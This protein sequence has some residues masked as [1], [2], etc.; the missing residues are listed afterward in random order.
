ML[1][2]FRNCYPQGSLVGELIDIDRGLYIV[3][4]SVQVEGIILATGLAAADKVEIAE[5]KARERA[6]AALRLESEGVRGNSV[7][8]SQKD[9]TSTV[10]HQTQSV[11]TSKQSAA[12]NGSEINNY[13]NV[14]NLSVPQAATPLEIPQAM[15]SPAPPVVEAETTSESETAPL[16]PVDSQTVPDTVTDN[17]GNLFEGTF[18]NQEAEMATVPLEAE[19]L[20]AMPSADSTV[21]DTTVK[22]DFYAIKHE[23]D[24]ELER[25]GWTN[26]EGRDFLKRNYGK[27]SRLRLTDEE[28]LEF[29]QHLKS[30]PTPE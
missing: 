30:L 26:D 11:P 6:I 8:S 24:I 19:E 13:S 16:H 2:K 12:N 29:L 14:V 9:S 15:E 25:L 21:P 5:D 28:L 22:I 20:S 4:V 27:P 7:V 1:E 23:T 3:K 18:D 10:R 17:S